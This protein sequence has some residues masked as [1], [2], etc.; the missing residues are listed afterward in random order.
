MLNT[1]GRLVDSCSEFKVSRYLK[2]LLENFKC[3]KSP[4]FRVSKRTLQRYA[5]NFRE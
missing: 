3:I 2:K 5:A 4:A 1:K